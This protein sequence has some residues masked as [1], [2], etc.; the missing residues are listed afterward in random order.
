MAAPATQPSKVVL[1]F[2]ENHTADNICSDIA[3]F[4]GDASLPPAADVHPDQPHDRRT[5]LDRATTAV[6]QRY[7]RA[8]LP[9]LYSLMD[10][11]TVCD[12]YFS[13]VGANSFPNHAFSI[14]ADA[15]GSTGNPHSGTPPFLTKPGVMVSLNAAGRTWAN[16]GGGF[17]FHYYTDPAM[18]ANVRPVT[19]LATDAA[20]GKLPDV[21]YVYAPSGRDF[22]PGRGT[23]MAASEQWLHQEILAVAN[24]THA[25]GSPLWTDVMMLVTFDDWGGW[26]D[27]VIPP[28]L[29][30]DA[31]GPY[32]MGSRV[33]MIVIGAYAKPGFVS[34]VQASHTSIV[35]YQERL[36][37]LPATNPRTVATGESALAD[38]Y[39]LTQ[40]PL[41]IPVTPT[42]HHPHPKP[43]RPHTLAGA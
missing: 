31:D 13:D 36:Y 20:S 37:G 15:G 7:S 33:P 8:Q 38:T 2:M 18:H 17:A 26:V 42:T 4:D 29:E 12:R 28:V 40:T 6:H 1:F 27:H 24:G 39:D 9:L 43:R 16:Y 25:D 22:H 41:P 34:H 3:G 32:R 11:Y 5:W 14:G 19:Q 23:S 35:A 10:R 21:S 30:S